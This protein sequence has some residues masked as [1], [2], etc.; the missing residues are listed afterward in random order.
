[1]MRKLLQL[2]ILI[3]QISS[4]MIKTWTCNHLIIQCPTQQTRLLFPPV[5]KVLPKDKAKWL[6]QLQT[7]QTLDHLKDRK[8]KGWLLQLI[9]WVWVTSNQT[10]VRWCWRL[11]QLRSK[12]IL[13]LFNLRLMHRKLYKIHSNWIHR[14]RQVILW[15]LKRQKLSLR[16]EHSTWEDTALIS[17][18]V[19]MMTVLMTMLLTSKLTCRT[20]P[21]ILTREKL[22]L[23][24]L[25]KFNT[26]ISSNNKTT[27]S[28]FLFISNT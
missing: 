19:K 5:C 17:S 12:V 23:K 26:C 8:L 22:R 7:L 27:A 2:V 6:C 13:S 16:K 24:M 9:K 20:Y 1:M 14:V 11:Q 28:L 4:L 21:R 10:T 3:L 18:S 15:W 25:L